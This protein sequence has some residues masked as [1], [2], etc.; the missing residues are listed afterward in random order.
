MSKTNQNILRLGSRGS[1]LAL[2]QTRMVQAALQSAHS[3][4]QI[5]LE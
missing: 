5:D 1:P 4:L 3:D 2:T